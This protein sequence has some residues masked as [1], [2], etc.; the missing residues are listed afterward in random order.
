VRLYNRGVEKLLEK[1]KL[2]EELALNK[3]LMQMYY[4]KEDLIQIWRIGKV[5]EADRFLEKWCKEVQNSDVTIIVKMA[6]QIASHR[7]RILNWIKHK[8]S[9]CP[10]EEFNN[11][12]KV[13]KKKRFRVLETW[14][15]S[16]LKY[17]NYEIR[18][19]LLR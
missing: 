3:P 10:L 7:T 17:L 1:E 5:N 4:L 15:I 14:N 13:F 18:Y 2:K 12:I 8:I 6:N 11:K 19:V 16:N 9:T